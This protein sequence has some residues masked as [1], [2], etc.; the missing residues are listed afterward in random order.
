MMKEQGKYPVIYMEF[1]DIYRPGISF[2]GF[3]FLLLNKI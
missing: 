2:A 1:I 3:Y